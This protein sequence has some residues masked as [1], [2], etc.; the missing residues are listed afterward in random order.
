MMETESELSR[1]EVAY[2]TGILG[3]RREREAAARS[4]GTMETETSTPQFVVGE[5]TQEVNDEDR[6]FNISN[7][8]DRYDS[9]GSGFFSEE[10][11]DKIAAFMN[12]DQPKLGGMEALT[13][14][15]LPTMPPLWHLH[16]MEPDD[17]RNW[18]LNKMAEVARLQL[19]KC[20]AA[21]PPATDSSVEGQGGLLTDEEIDEA[22]DSVDLAGEDW[23]MYLYQTRIYR[24]IAAAAAAKNRLAMVKMATDCQAQL[25]LREAELAA[26]DERITDLEAACGTAVDDYKSVMLELAAAET[27]NQTLR[28]VLEKALEAVRSELLD[29]GTLGDTDEMVFLKR[30]GIDELIEAV[31]NKMPSTP[32]TPDASGGLVDCP[33]CKGSGRCACKPDMSHRCGKCNGTGKKD[34][35]PDA[36]GGLVDCPTCKGSPFNK[37]Q[38]ALII[39]KDCEGTG[40]QQ[41]TGK[42]GG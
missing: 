16:N 40:V 18:I 27:S 17:L 2:Q 10:R 31:R 1:E 22:R 12:A 24:A 7:L 41:G 35:P 39:C 11:A 15:E 28:A 4:T 34:L 3:M 36:S 8:F 42:V 21:T 5:V 25:D 30:A 20:A 26:K 14:G 6:F 19:A 33:E 38:T 13:L 23:Q 37:D 9:D 32:P 29:L